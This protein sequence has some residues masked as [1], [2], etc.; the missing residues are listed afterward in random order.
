[1]WH[2]EG[3]YDA[4]A[5]R[6]FTELP[7]HRFLLEYDGPRS[8][9]FAPLR[10]LPKGKVAVL[11]LVSTKVP[12]LETVDG[13]RRRMDEAAKVLPLDQ[14]AISPQCGFASDVVGNLI[15]TDDQRRKLDI[16]V[17]TARQIWG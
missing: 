12:E 1:M 5:E 3:T 6:L 14:L 11:G 9:S 15:S 17:E 10:F 4:I 8:G 7:H 2:R 16:V 13:L